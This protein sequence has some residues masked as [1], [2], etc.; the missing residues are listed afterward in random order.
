MASIAAA[1][2]AGDHTG[3]PL[4]GWRAMLAATGTRATTQG[5]PYGDGEHRRCGKGRATTQGR[6]YGM[7]GSDLI[8]PFGAPSPE[9]E[10]C[11]ATGTRA[12]GRSP[13]RVDAGLSQN[14]ITIQEVCRCRG[15]VAPPAGKYAAFRSGRVALR[16]P[17][18]ST[19]RFV[20]DGRRCAAPTGRLCI[21]SF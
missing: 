15:G 12:I 7:A 11:A 20:Q 5:R 16:R 9:G 4:R 8:R 19:L 6:P 13:L 21:Y 3:S 10:G 1:G 14:V 18:E 2:N 17:P